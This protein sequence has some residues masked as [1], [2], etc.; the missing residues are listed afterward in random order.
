MLTRDKTVAPCRKLNW[1]LE[2]KPQQKEGTEKY[3]QLA[4][5]ESKNV[6]M[7]GLVRSGCSWEYSQI[8]GPYFMWIWEPK[9]ILP[10]WSGKHHNPQPHPQVRTWRKID[11]R[12]IISGPVLGR[13]VHNDADN[14]GVLTNTLPPTPPAPNRKVPKDYLKSA[15]HITNK[16][17]VSRVY[18]IKEMTRTTQ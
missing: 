7:L 14:A 17:Q 10:L 5:G 2:L 18:I 1:D 11:L 9:C 15:A 16:I 6:W 13:P 12:L 4:K 3:M 8:L